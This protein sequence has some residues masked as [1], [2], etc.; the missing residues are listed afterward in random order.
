MRALKI[1]AGGLMLL[2]GAPFV[3]MAVHDLI[4]GDG[5]TAAGVLVGLV[6]FFGGIA[7]G[8]GLLLRS[9]ART[10]RAPAIPAESLEV[11]ALR[12]AASAGGT[13]G[14]AQLAAAA[15]VPFADA[16]EIL[17]KLQREGACQVLVEASGAELYR[18]PDVALGPA[19][20]ARAKDLLE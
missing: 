4:T 9:A 1:A 2:V 15:G 16:R 13:L 7:T 6:V 11:L 17:A 14:A 12:A 18:F 3:G 20:T 5:K 8:G 19:G 10:G